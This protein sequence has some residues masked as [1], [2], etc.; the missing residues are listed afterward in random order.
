[1][2]RKVILGLTLILIFATVGYSKPRILQKP[3]YAI[4]PVVAAEHNKRFSAPL[5]NAPTLI[6]MSPCKPSPTT[7]L[8]SKPTEITS[9]ILEEIEK[10]FIPKIPGRPYYHWGKPHTLIGL[11]KRGPR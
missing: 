3:K 11:G 4:D 6:N 9:S 10:P 2:I 8:D 7:T 1:M 5:S